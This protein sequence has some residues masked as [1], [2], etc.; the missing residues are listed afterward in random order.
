MS[1]SVNRSQKSKIDNSRIFFNVQKS[2]EM[3]LWKLN[4][5]PEQRPELR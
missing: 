5:C 4:V 2:L 1:K 3:F